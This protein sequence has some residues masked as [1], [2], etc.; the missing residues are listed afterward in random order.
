MTNELIFLTQAVIIACSVLIAARFG[1]S[2]LTAL[3]MLSGVLANLFVLKQIDLFGLSVTAADAYMIGASLSLN[4]LQEYYGRPAARQAIWIA[5]FGQMV[6]LLMALLHCAFIPSVFDSTQLHYCAVLYH[7]PR[8]IIAS[9][10]AYNASEW[11]NYFAFNFLKKTIGDRWF[12]VRAFT[13]TTSAQLI[14]TLLFSVLGLYG[15]VHSTPNIICMSL[16]IKAIVIGVT[17]PFMGLL[18]LAKNNTLRKT[19]C[20]IKNE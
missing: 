6:F 7:L 16:A 2:G 3:I 19:A 12:A 4:T 5:F 14:D 20:L 10:I 18:S 13:A 15:L 9:I 11:A 1:K 8:L 17:S